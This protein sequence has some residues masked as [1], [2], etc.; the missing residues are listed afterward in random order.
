[1]GK[2]E[3]GKVAMAKKAYL[4]STKTGEEYEIVKQNKEQKKI[5]LKDKDGVIFDET[6]DPE[7][8]KKMGYEPVVK[9]V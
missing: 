1:M 4:K 5:W 7:R 3:G 6:F 2:S 8:L 9:E